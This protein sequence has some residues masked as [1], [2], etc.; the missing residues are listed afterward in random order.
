M[1]NNNSPDATFSRAPPRWPRATL[2]A[3]PLRAQ[4]PAAAAITPP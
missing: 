3:E 1:N 4:A 2:F